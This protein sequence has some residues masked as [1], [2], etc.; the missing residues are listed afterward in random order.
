MKVSFAVPVYNV[1][2]YIERCARSLFGQTLDEVEYVFVD[3]CSLDNS[4]NLLLSVLEDYPE[5]KPFVKIIRHERNMGISASRRDSYLGTTGDYVI[6]VDSDDMAEPTLAEKLYNKAI[7]TGADMVVCDAYRY[8][9]DCRYPIES[10]PYGEGENGS[11]IRDAII[12]RVT[13][14]GIWCKLFRRD[15]FDHDRMVWPKGNYSE[16][17]LISAQCAFYAK[18]IAYVE[19]PL[20]HYL[21]NEVSICNK[22]DPRRREKNVE[23][24]KMNI[25]DLDHF[26]KEHN[27]EE[28]YWFGLFLNKFYAKKQLLPYVEQV[29]Y[30]RLW[31]STFPEL[32][33]TLFWGNT[34]YKS[35]YKQKI[36]MAAI[37]LG[38]YPKFKHRLETKRFCPNNRWRVW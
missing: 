12:N 24:Y 21:Y 1:E 31:F 16:D 18:K 38:L 32:N 33:H 23:E 11:A 10:A 29:K 14:P 5:R 13:T 37:W 28:K 22:P 9:K 30:R 2:P 8:K 36:W 6:A 35:S 20:Y 34:L 3:D 4:I 25:S 26:L 15:L 7:Q 17:V 27:V 19:E